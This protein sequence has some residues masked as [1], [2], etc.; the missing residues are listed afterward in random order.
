M[1]ITS[2]RW[3][4]A[5]VTAAAAPASAVLATMVFAGAGASHQAAGAC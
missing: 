5:A 3:W 1:E 2:R 4:F